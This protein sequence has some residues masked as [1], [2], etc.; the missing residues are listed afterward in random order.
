MMTDILLNA[1]IMNIHLELTL[2]GR[3]ESESKEY[4]FR[5]SVCCYYNW[6]YSR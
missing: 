1:I 6:Y 2:E 4:N 5:N 3:Y